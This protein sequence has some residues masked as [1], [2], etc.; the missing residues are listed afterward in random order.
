[1][2][3]P[4]NFDFPCIKS[5]IMVINN[6]MYNFVYHSHSRKDKGTSC[7]NISGFTVD[8]YSLTEKS[9][10]TFLIHATEKSYIHS[11]MLQ[12]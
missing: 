1:M 2:G 5:T 10:M 9:D 3:N 12:A 7:E 11:N 4:G 6:H 8:L